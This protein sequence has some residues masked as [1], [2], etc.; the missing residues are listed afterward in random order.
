VDPNLR[1][2]TSQLESHLM[3]RVRVHAEG[4]RGRLEIDFASPEE[5]SRLAALILDGRR[6]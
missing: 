6:L 5:L 4:R 2:L 3:T 1:A